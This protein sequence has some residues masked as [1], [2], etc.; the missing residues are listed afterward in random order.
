ME[1]FKKKVLLASSYMHGD[2]IN[3]VQDAFQKNWITTAGENIDA[4]EYAVAEKV[5]VKSVSYTHLTLPTKA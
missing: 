3:F 4:L 1:P 5:G 2:E